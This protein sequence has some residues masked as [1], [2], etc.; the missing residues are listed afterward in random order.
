[1]RTQ[2]RN[3][4]QELQSRNAREDERAAQV[5]KESTD[6]LSRLQQQ[7]CS[8]PQVIRS[9]EVHN[10][11]A[12]PSSDSSGWRAAADNMIGKD[13]ISAPHG[14]IDQQQQHASNTA[15]R[16]NAVAD[17]FSRAPMSPPVSSPVSS[18]SRSPTTKGRE[19]EGHGSDDRMAQLKRQMEQTAR[20]LELLQQKKQHEPEAEE[21]IVASKTAEAA[22]KP[23][24][25]ASKPTETKQKQA[26]EQEAAQA[27]LEDSHV[28]KYLNT[29]SVGCEW[30]QYSGGSGHSVR[31]SDYMERRAWCV[32]KYR[33]LLCEYAS[34]VYAS[35]VCCCV[36]MRV[37]YAAV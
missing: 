4:K 16:L 22:S 21:P 28:A 37:S 29:G 24:E 35:N 7:I 6:R 17:R 1:M 34:N 25:T 8:P 26:K 2:L 32:R 9:P 13:P 14:D 30:A 5:K 31:W 33:M 11:T 10:S 23:A 12:A 20:E 36:N 3:L 18:A 15:V 19:E 27:P